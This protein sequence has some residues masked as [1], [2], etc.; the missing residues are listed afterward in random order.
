MSKEEQSK[1]LISAPTLDLTVKSSLDSSF[2]SIGNWPEESWWHLFESTQLNELIQIA[3]TQNPN[4]QSIEKKVD[5]AKQRSVIARSQLFPLISFNAS[6]DWQYLSKHGL[7][8]A[9]NPTIPLNANLI[10]LTLAFSYEFDFWSKFR[11]QFRAAL[12]RERAE[13]ASAAETNLIVTT[14]VAQAFFALKTNLV[15]QELIVQLDQ[16]RKK[17]FDLQH[18]LLKQALYSKL[19][20]YLAEELLLESGKMVDEIEKQV[21]EDRHL[22]N[23]LIGNGPESPLIVDT[24]LPNLPATLLIPEQLS[25]NLLSRRPDLM[26]QIW[27]VEALAHEVGAAR[28]SYF[29]NINLA[30]FIGF[31]SLNYSELFKADSSVIGFNPAMNLP[32]YTAGAIQANIDSKQSQFDSA[33]FSYN[34]LILK[35]SKEVA[36]LLVLA[37][38]IFKQQAKQDFIVHN[39]AERHALIQIRQQNGL[40]N[41]LQLYAFEE[42]LLQKKIDNID[43]V[44]GQYVA[45]VKLIKALGGGYTADFIP[46]E[47]E[48]S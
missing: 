32:I 15:K 4:L 17:A 6:D 42:E 2:F 16:V 48:A 1:N 21:A 41:A 9:L 3:L 39:A 40:E 12:G 18:I 47:K 31:E 23:I 8:R 34:E 43:L 37:K 46:I 38:S 5:E 22:V 7:Y 45:T 13:Q 36:D 20:V 11:N 30:S 26:A 28:A 27:R 35:S 44:Y 14:A 25:L 24:L 33:L 29:P 19:P 10:D